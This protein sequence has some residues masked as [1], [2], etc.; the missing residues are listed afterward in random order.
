ML[1]AFRVFILQ[2]I[3]NY[4]INEAKS[5]TFPS[6]M[7]YSCNRNEQKMAVLMSS[8]GTWKLY[9]SKALKKKHL[10]TFHHCIYVAKG[11]NECTLQ[12]SDCICTE[13]RS[14]FSYHDKRISDPERIPAVRARWDHDCLTVNCYHHGWGFTHSTPAHTHTHE[15]SM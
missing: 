7:K 5:T 13:T 9:L 8:T 6:E 10:I 1:T 12:G 2:I 4:H 14:C 11:R 15:H 3:L